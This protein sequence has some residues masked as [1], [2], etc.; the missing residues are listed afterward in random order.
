[1]PP[2]NQT[3]AAS[4]I[5]FSVRSLSYIILIHKK[6]FFTF[7]LSTKLNLFWRIDQRFDCLETDPFLMNDSYLEN[8]KKKNTWKSVKGVLKKES[9][10]AEQI[11][12]SKFRR[13]CGLK[14]QAAFTVGYLPMCTTVTNSGV[15]NPLEWL[16]LEWP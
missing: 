4:F 1:M 3:L 12:R 13:K 11:K 16:K 2:S 10:N 5:R 14:K 15:E 8:A 7:H 6:F 9:R